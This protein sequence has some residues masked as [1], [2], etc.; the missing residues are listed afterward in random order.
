MPWRS[1]HPVP[2][3]CHNQC[4][5]PSGPI[6]GQTAVQDQALTHQRGGRAGG[7]NCATKARP[8]LNFLSTCRISSF[9]QSDGS[10]FARLRNNKRSRVGQ[11]DM[12]LALICIIYVHIVVV[13][14]I[15]LSP[16]AAAGQIFTRPVDGTQRLLGVYSVPSALVPAFQGPA[17]APW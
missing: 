9:E 5:R 8:S 3:T 11:L 6:S 7:C 16:L 17:R 15:A 12:T 2:S 13:E 10:T 1:A 4:T 14:V